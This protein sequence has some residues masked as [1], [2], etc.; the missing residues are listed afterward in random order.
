MS[1]VTGYRHE[2]FIPMCISEKNQSFIISYG[3]VPLGIGIYLLFAYL[4]K[5]KE[6]EEVRKMA[7][8]IIN[9]VA[10]VIKNGK[11]ARFT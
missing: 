4:M 1:F 10:G 3:C 8:A 9:R 7:Q 6:V 11:L 5:I 2:C